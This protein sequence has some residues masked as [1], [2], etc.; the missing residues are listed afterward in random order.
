M[1]DYHEL[2]RAF[3]GELH[4]PSHFGLG[5]ELDRCL[6]Y[7]GRQAIK[8]MCGTSKLSKLGP[9]SVDSFHGAAR[10]V[11]DVALG[12]ESGLANLRSSNSLVAEATAVA[13]RRMLNLHV[14]LLCMVERSCNRQV[15]AFLQTIVLQECY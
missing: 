12:L 2:W 3:V 7:S 4:F 14:Q 9:A 6:W 13:D 11:L 15:R 5:G 8:Q 10:F 1:G